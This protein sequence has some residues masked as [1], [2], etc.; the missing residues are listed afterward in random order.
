MSSSRGGTTA[1][2]AVKPF[3]FNS[4]EGKVSKTKEPV[5]GA[6]AKANAYNKNT[7]AQLISASKQSQMWQSSES[8]AAVA[9]ACLQA[10][11]IN[12]ASKQQKYLQSKQQTTAKSSARVSVEPGMRKSM[13]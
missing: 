2:K 5:A 3:I 12:K 10:P 8:T 9:G 6:G 4:Y 7:L 13:G 1:P 11:R